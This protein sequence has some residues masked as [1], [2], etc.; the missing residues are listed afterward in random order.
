MRNTSCPI[1]DL[2]SR[3]GFLLQ[4]V[5]AS[6]GAGAAACLSPRC[7]AQ[8]PAAAHARLRFGFTTYQW[9]QDWDLAALIANLTK[10]EVYGAELRT[11]S[12]Y[13][14]GVE[15][16]L[17]D[18]QR[19]EVRQRFADSP[20]ELVGLASGERM[21]WPE[22]EKLQAAIENSKAYLKLSH[23][24][25]GSGVRVFPNQ[26]HPSVPREKTIEQIAR[27]L[28]QIGQFAA[29]YAQEV[30][31]EAHGAAGDLPTIAAIMD[32]VTQPKVRVKLNSDARD[33]AEF[34]QRFQRVK[35]RLARTLHLHNLNDSKFPYALQTRLLMAMGWDGWALLEVSDAVDDRVL[36]LIE[37]RQ[38]WQRLVD[39]AR[40]ALAAPAK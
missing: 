7:S 6:I 1:S 28:N 19:R 37:Q 9:G 4:T 10:A 11:S 14:H 38:I 25:G 22:P 3:R 32:Q 8:E 40:T 5:C 16:T 30:R 36:A 31:L 21:D 27:A 12:G 33:A 24:I 18:Q 15:L 26:F 34:E 17:S 13:A 35:D 2:R 23:D 29:D 20:I 39:E